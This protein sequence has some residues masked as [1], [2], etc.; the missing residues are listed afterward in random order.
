[1]KWKIA[2]LLV[3]TLALLASGCIGPQQEDTDRSVYDGEDKIIVAVSIL[4]QAEFV[5]QIAGKRV[6]TIVMIPPGASPATHEPTPGQLTDVADASMYAIVG[7][8]LSFEDVW[9][10]KIRAVNQDMLI[11]DSSEGITLRM[12]EEGTDPHIWTSPQNAKVMVENIYQGLVRID[13]DNQDTYYANKEEY[14]DKLDK[15]DADVRNTL[16]GKEGSSFM[17]FHPS[18][19]YFADEYDLNMISIEIEGKEPSAHQL[20][21][22]IDT[23]KQNNITIIFV[24]V[25][26]SSQSAEAIAQEIDGTVVPIDPLAEDYVENIGIVT[27]AFVQGLAE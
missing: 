26:F 25:Q 18:W 27:G 1:M 13:P 16:S 11:V 8:G 17:V 23:A 14:L 7:S 10:T 4:P 22:I 6:R 20:S 3:M 2:F 24:Q 5:E 19:G 15:A 12:M 9:L 21:Q